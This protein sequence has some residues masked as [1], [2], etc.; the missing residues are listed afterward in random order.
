MNNKQTT[1]TST[2]IPIRP[3]TDL[4]SKVVSGARKSAVFS[5]SMTR[6]FDHTDFRNKCNG[7][8]SLHKYNGKKARHFKTYVT[9]HMPEEKPDSVLIQAGGNDLPTNATVLEIA[10]HIIE[11]GIVCKDMGASRIMISSVLP[12]RDFHLQLKRQELNKLLESLC[13]IHNFVFIPNTK[14]TLSTH[15]SNDGVHLNDVGTQLL[16]DTFVEYLN[17]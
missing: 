2:T 6:D 16:Q 9:A 12:R 15:I 4:Y 8:V 11:T 13:E 17:A 14:M 10:N 5:T 3:G 7:E 1:H